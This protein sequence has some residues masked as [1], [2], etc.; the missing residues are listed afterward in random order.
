M[1]G[2]PTNINGGRYPVILK[3]G[4]RVFFMISLKDITIAFKIIIIIIIIITGT[5]G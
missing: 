5:G 1:L 2:Y 4:I 3:S